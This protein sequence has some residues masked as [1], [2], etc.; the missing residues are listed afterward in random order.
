V[1]SSLLHIL[2]VLAAGFFA[3][4][5]NSIAA[6]GTLIAFPVLIWAGVPAY[7]AN[8][9]CSI[10][11]FPGYA[12]GAWG[13]RHALKEVAGIR[14]RLVVIA[15]VG[16]VLGASL[17]LVTPRE[18]FSKVVPFLIFASVVLF[19]ARPWIAKQASALP[20]DAHLKTAKISVA[21]GVCIFLAGTYGAYFGAAL[22]II[23]LALF[24]SFLTTSMQA[25]NGLKSV[26]S[27]FCVAAGAVIYIAAGRVDWEPALLL[28]ASSV[29][30]GFV[31]AR[32][33]LRIPDQV[34]RWAVIVVGLVASVALFAKF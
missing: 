31:G 1:D 3:G 16:G 12:G 23:L 8:I 32:V 22:G 27:F 13:Y 14:N 4:A 26:V 5:V 17:L 18:A 7:S 11:L 21:L 24:G 28:L 2:V 29:V 6:G 25:N 19:I 20:S 33:G 10:G 34:L 30:G 9:A 15:S